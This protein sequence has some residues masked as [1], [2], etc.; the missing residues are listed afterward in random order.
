M[1]L[2]KKQIDFLKLKS[3]PSHFLRWVMDTSKNYGV[4][5]IK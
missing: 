2:V 3:E 1:R 4:S 5:A